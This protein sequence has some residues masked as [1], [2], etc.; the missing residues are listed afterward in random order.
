[1]P[2]HTAFGYSYIPCKIWNLEITGILWFEYYI[3]IMY[4]YIINWKISFSSGSVH[5]SAILPGISPTVQHCYWIGSVFLLYGLKWLT[6]DLI[7]L[8]RPYYSLWSAEFFCTVTTGQIEL[9]TFLQSYTKR[10]YL[11]Y[12]VC[13]E[14]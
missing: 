7:V 3:L 14:V 8:A 6:G 5:K 4:R 1:M 9:R 10:L 12:T 13:S 2:I 11:L